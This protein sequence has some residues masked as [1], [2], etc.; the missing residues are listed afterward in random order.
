MCHASV[1]VAPSQRS[2]FLRLWI[3]IAACVAIA[4]GVYA[5]SNEPPTADPSA[6]DP[7]AADPSAAADPGAPAE[8]AG[9]AETD[10]HEGPSYSPF[11]VH[12]D[13]VTLPFHMISFKDVGMSLPEGESIVAYETLA[14]ALSLDLQRELADI[15]TEV[16]H[17][18]EITDPNA[19]LACE[20][21]H[22]YV[23]LWRAGRGWGYSLW[24][25]CGEDDEFAHR[26]VAWTA[27]LAE[28]IHQSIQPLSRDI[29]T[30]L[31]AASRTGCFTRHC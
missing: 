17:Q 1:F 28:G 22:I 29:A 31:V 25:G 27:P 8:G 7:S 5:S 26:E 9:I 16:R 14:E 3:S 15:S 6:A 10:A 13:H 21:E 30:Q 12:T 4:F 24:S 11:V 20:G 19:H 2:L 23:D 18:V